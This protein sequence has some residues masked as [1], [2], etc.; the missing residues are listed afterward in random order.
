M[1]DTENMDDN[2]KMAFENWTSRIRKKVRGLKKEKKAS[3]KKLA[4]E[5]EWH[6]ELIEGERE[7]EGPLSECTYEQVVVLFYCLKTM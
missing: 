5:F 3:A 4:E 1:D 2:Q 7:E 6:L